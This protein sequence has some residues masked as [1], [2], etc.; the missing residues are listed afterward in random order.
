MATDDQNAITAAKELIRLH[1]AHAGAKAE[2]AFRA[3]CRNGDGDQI[4]H[5]TK[6]REAIERLRAG[7]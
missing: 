3:A 7:C 4:M 5:W 1:G 2:E 6:T